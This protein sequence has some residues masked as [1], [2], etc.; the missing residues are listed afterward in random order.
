MVSCI[1]KHGLK[2]N[3]QLVICLPLIPLPFVSNVMNYTSLI[4]STAPDD[5][6][7]TTKLFNFTSSNTEFDISVPIINDNLIELTEMFQ[8][9][10]RVVSKHG[11]EIIL[12]P[13]QAIVNIS[14]EDGLC[15]NIDNA[16]CH[17]V[18]IATKFK[19]CIFEKFD[20]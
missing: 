19:S 6:T 11:V 5:Y 7:S 18:L 13:G 10:L 20:F 3:S 1:L 2:W 16:C 8:A 4:L 14:S 12:Q 9:N 17:F 15:M